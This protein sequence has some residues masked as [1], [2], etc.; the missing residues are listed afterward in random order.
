MLIQE[1][2]KHKIKALEYLK[3]SAD[4]GFALAQYG[5][6]S[7]L[8]YGENIEKNIDESLRHFTLAVE[9]DE[10]EAQVVFRKC[11]LSK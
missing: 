8:F 10:V 6:G 11:L 1:M 9:Q 3:K 4:G 7:L 2:Q 5:Y